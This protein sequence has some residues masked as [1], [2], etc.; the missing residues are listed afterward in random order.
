ARVLSALD[1][2]ARWDPRRAADLDSTRCAA[3][4][5]AVRRRRAAGAEHA[6]RRAAQA[7]GTGAGVRDRARVRGS[8]PRGAGPGRQHLLRRR[9]APAAA[10]GRPAHPGRDGV[11][12]LRCRSRALRRRHVRLDRSRRADRGE[13]AR[14]PVA[15]R[16]HGPV[17]L[18]QHGARNRARPH[19]VGAGRARDHRRE[20]R[21]SQ[22]RHAARRHAGSGH[23]LAR[24]GDARIAAAGVD[25]C[26]GGGAAAGPED[27]RGG[28]SGVSHGIHRRGRGGA[29][30][31]ALAGQPV[32]RLSAGDDPRRELPAR[33][34]AR[35]KVLP[36]ASPGVVI[37]EPRV[38]EDGRGLFFESYH[39]ARYAEAGLPERFVQDNHSRSAPGTLRGLHYQL[40]QPQGKL[41]RVV[42]GSVFDVAVDIRRGS[43]TFARWV[44]VELS[45]ANKRQLFIPPGF[46]HGFCV[47]SEASEIAYKCT[48]YY[49]SDDERGVAWNDPT[50]AIAW[51]LASPPLLSD[52]DKAFPRLDYAD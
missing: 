40:S 8:R 23:R 21:V 35:V 5:R 25:L 28:R 50:I 29:A 32:R 6:L 14:A 9:A 31:G 49:V 19:T 46:A 18:R 12:L 41:V 27:R 3:V 13:A 30:G 22:G 42:A 20:Q 36:T 48:E 45:A 38:F 37:V 44:G 16:R 1:P 33:G 15:L 10:A 51:P 4:P 11:R 39:A 7:R 17:L 52:K 24:H 26:G 34:T 43:P 47:P 2:H